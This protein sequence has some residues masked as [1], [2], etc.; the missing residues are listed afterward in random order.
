MISLHKRK[1]LSV[2]VKYSRECSHKIIGYPLRSGMSWFGWWIL[3]HSLCM[4]TFPMRAPQRYPGSQQ[5]R[6]QQFLSLLHGLSFDLHFLPSLHTFTCVH[7]NCCRFDFLHFPLQ[8]WLLSEQ[9][10]LCRLHI[11]LPIHRMVFSERRRCISIKI[12]YKNE[13]FTLSL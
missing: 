4:H 3:R 13:T 6:L 7:H 9:T 5:F 12:L 1:L 2:E 10:S 8:H 11:P